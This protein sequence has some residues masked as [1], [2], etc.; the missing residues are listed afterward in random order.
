MASYLSSQSGRGLQ[1]AHVI[2]NPDLP[3][4]QIRRAVWRVRSDLLR[5]V[6]ERARHRGE[7]RDGVD[8]LTVLEL[9]FAPI[10]MR[11]LFTGEPVDDEYC[12]TVSELVFRAVTIPVASR[13]DR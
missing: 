11:E 7:L 1:L 3:T 12:R 2:G 10:H 13:D 5:I 4:T 6:V 9:L 8:D